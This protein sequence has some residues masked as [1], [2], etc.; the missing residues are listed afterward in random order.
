MLVGITC[1][2]TQRTPTAILLSTRF[3]LPP[4][5]GLCTKRFPREML[6]YRGLCTNPCESGGYMEWALAV[7]DLAANLAAGASRTQ[8]AER[9]S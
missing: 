5:M 9:L 2:A 1:R 7:I 3:T 8:S 6:S 4:Q